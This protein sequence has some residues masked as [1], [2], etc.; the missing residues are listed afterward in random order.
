VLRTNFF[1]K[2]QRPGRTS[3]TDWLATALRRQ[4]PLTV[5]D[6]V[7]FSPLSLDRLCDLIMLA[8]ERRVAGVFNLGSREGM[9]K[10]D[11]AFVFADALGLS[12]ASVRRGRSTDAALA[13]RRP[14]DMRMDCSRFERTFGLTLPSLR[15]ELLSIMPAYTS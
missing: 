1:G 7:L 12:T 5:F 2:S 8:A 9:S 10:A 14:T 6:D 4:D 15:D 11:F 3:F 13:A